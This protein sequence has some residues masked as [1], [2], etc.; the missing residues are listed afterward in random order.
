MVAPIITNNIDKIKTL[1]EEHKVKELYVFGSAV[2]DKFNDKSD[3]D[4]VIDFE[5][6]DPYKFADNYFSLS[7]KL[8]KLLKRKVDFVTEKYLQNKYF[9]DEV[10]QTKVKLI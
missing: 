8:E 1:C 9:I 4:F 5:N 2:S 6:I 3:V 10:K 7:E